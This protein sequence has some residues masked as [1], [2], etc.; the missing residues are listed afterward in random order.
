MTGETRDLDYGSYREL[1]AMGCSA[2][3][4]GYGG[5]AGIKRHM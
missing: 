3:Y 5:F 1:E 4:G 2:Y